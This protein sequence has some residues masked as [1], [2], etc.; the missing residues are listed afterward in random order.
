MWM[1]FCHNFVYHNHLCMRILTHRHY[2]RNWSMAYG[3]GMPWNKDIYKI[4]PNLTNSLIVMTKN[5]IYYNRKLKN[6]I[7]VQDTLEWRYIQVPLKA[8]TTFIVVTW[9]NM[10]RSNPNFNSILPIK[11]CL[12][13][14]SESKNN[15]YIWQ[16]WL[17]STIILEFV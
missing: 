17:V 15:C 6:G 10:I 16:C 7:W 12:H 4:H 14:K 8:N 9:V 13:T 11:I 3:C 2:I 5:H 1:Y